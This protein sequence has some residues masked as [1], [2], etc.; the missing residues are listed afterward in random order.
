M[1]TTIV[2]E[3][4][5]RPRGFA[6]PLQVEPMDPV[7]VADIGGTNARFALADPVTLELAHIGQ[8]LCSRHGSIEAALADYLSPLPF[9]PKSAALAIAGPIAGERIALTNS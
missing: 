3:P 9:K 6:T 5:N 7:L 4:R 2:R 8:T 1:R